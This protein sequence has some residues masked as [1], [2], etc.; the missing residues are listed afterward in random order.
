MGSINEKAQESFRKGLV[1]ELQN[2]IKN[3]PDSA[4]LSSEEVMALINAVL[5][6]DKERHETVYEPKA[7]DFSVEK[8]MSVF[9]SADE[10]VLKPFTPADKSFF[11][12]VSRQYASQ[13]LQ[14]IFSE[15]N[16]YHW[17][18]TQNEHTFY[19]IA[20]KS[21]YPIGYIGIKD[22]RKAIWEIAIELDRQHCNHGYGPKIILLFLSRLSEITLKD[23]Y[24]AK[25][26][27]D[28]IA[29]QKCMEKIGAKLI[30]L[31]DNFFRGPIEKERFESENLDSINDNMIALAKR[32]NV[33][34]RNLLSHVLEYEITI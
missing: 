4:L 25:V 19:C 33:E 24:C 22:T 14:I 2:R 32:L 23:Y 34:P 26:E 28:N 17:N 15:E 30:G 29:S 6:E 16:D 11:Y 3:I 7:W 21:G 8:Q 20:E 31:A 10:F 5:L 12:Q 13:P 9:A 27:V 1:Q 18:E